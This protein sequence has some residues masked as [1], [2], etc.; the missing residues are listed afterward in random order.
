MRMTK[1]IDSLNQDTQY[2]TFFKAQLAISLPSISPDPLKLKIKVSMKGSL[3]N[4]PMGF[5]KQS[6]KSPIK[7]IPFF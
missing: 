4:Y 3:K 6:A 7:P 1:Q 2:F 5:P